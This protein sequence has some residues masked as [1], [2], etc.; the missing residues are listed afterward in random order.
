MEYYVIK[1]KKK[2][3]SIG[4]PLFHETELFLYIMK[5]IALRYYFQNNPMHCHDRLDMFDSTIREE[6]RKMSNDK[7]Q[8]RKQK[9]KIE[10]LRKKSHP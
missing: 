7:K 9:E 2:T 3:N 5:F 6:R 1:A 8:N 10:S 4:L